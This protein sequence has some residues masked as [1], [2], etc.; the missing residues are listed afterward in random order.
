MKKMRMCYPV[1]KQGRL[2]VRGPR[3]HEH[4]LGKNCMTV[5]APT[6]LSSSP[7]RQIYR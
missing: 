4:A 5:F 1:C 7:L 6:L 2:K 3:G